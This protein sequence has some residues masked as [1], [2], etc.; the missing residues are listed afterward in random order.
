MILEVLADPKFQIPTPEYHKLQ[1]LIRELKETDFAQYEL[2]ENFYQYD[3]IGAMSPAHGYLLWQHYECTPAPEPE[4]IKVDRTEVVSNAKIVL[5]NKTVSTKDK[6]TMLR[7]FQGKELMDLTAVYE[8]LK[9]KPEKLPAAPVVDN[10]TAPEP[11]ATPK[12]SQAD[13][14]EMHSD[15]WNLLDPDSKRVF[16]KPKPSNRSIEAS[17]GLGVPSFAAVLGKLANRV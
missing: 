7:H 17:F 11:T 6:Q 12:V 10:S 16:K 1:L 8:D 14:K 3:Q 4:P 15:F 9:S 5:R 13:V 2:Y